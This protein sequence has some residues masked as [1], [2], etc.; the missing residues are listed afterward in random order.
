[1]EMKNGI[2]ALDATK[3]IFVIFKMKFTDLPK[4]KPGGN[5]R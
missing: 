5:V 3:L 4:K 1:M 2:I